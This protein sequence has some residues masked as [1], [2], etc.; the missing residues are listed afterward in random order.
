MSHPEH[1]DTVTIAFTGKLDNGE[2]FYEV[3]KDKP[4]QIKVGTSDLPPSLEQAILKLTVGEEV[5]VRLPPE[6]G[7]GARQK[8]LLQTIDNQ[9]MI[10]SL[11]PK[12]GMILSLKVEKEGTEQK[13]PATVIEVNGS[14]VTVDY[15]HPLAG[16]HLNY[17]LTLLEI[18]K[19]AD[20]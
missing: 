16:H 3:T 12:P 1:N 17:K 10:D 8:D 13:V 18:T 20:N 11:N 14:E 19:S 6:E 4:L 5:D 7:Y 9:Q 2:V 15:N